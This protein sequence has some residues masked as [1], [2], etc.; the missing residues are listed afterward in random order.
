MRAFS[1]NRRKCGAGA[2][3]VVVMLLAMLGTWSATASVRGRMAAR[4]DLRRGRYKILSYGLP[5]LW[6]PE[7]A[8]LLKERYGVEL[9]PVAG[10]IVSKTLFSYVDSYDDVVV[11]EVNH[12][13]GHDVFKECAEDARKGAAGSDRASG[14]SK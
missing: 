2:G 9:H 7:Y 11:A 3:F 1:T 5:P 12:N 6:L 8:R 13:F 14:H 4:F 10:C